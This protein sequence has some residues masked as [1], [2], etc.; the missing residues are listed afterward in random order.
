MEDKMVVGAFGRA[1]NHGCPFNWCP[2]F[3]LSF[4]GLVRALKAASNK[5]AALSAV[6]TLSS[7]GLNSWRTKDS[8]CFQSITE[9]R[10]AKNNYL[11]STLVFSQEYTGT[12]RVCRSVL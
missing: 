7:V 4:W 9:I 3:S 12:G 11:C 2:P 10:T 6:D 5:C 8:Q 1:R